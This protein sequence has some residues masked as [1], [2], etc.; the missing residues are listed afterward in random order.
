MGGNGTTP[1]KIMVSGA[2]P[3]SLNGSYS[4]RSRATTCPTFDAPFER[5]CGRLRSYPRSRATPRPT[6]KGATVVEGADA[7]WNKGASP[8]WYKHDKNGNCI[9]S[10]AGNNYN[11]W[12]IA[13]ELGHHIY[14]RQGTRN[15]GLWATDRLVPPRE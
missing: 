8:I 12:S 6:N 3:A 13:L 7:F 2:T 11:G 14:I 9:L 4:P 10:D 1:P 5:Y 15:G